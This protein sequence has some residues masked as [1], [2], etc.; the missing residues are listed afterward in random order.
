[1]S[2]ESENF[3]LLANFSNYEFRNNLSNVWSGVIDPP[4]PERPNR[5]VGGVSNN[6][7]FEL[8]FAIGA[9]HRYQSEKHVCEV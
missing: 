1:M 8:E 5:S 2:L 3:E 9:R 4:A 7:V 6:S